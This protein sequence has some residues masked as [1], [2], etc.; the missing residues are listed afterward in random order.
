MKSFWR[1]IRANQ[2]ATLL[3]VG[4]WLATLVVARLTWNAGI[5]VPVVVLLFTTPLVAGGLVARW[6]ATTSARSRDRIWGGTLAGVLSAGLTLL[7]M[8]GGVVSELI[9]WARGDRFRG[10]EVLEF[11]I[12][13]ALLGALLGLVG[14]VLAITLDPDRRHA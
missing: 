13:G 10:G 7:I 8:T 12:A 1:D 2:R 14:A 4:Y 6:R 5:P 3:L 11:C 9:G